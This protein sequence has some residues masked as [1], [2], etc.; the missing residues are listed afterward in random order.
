[1]P[2]VAIV[3]DHERLAGLLSQ[4]LA[5]AGIESDRFGNAR[6]A[7]YGIDR[8]DYALLIVDRGLPDGDGLAFLRTLRAAGRMM[9]C[10]MLTARDALHDRIDGLESGAD[11]Y[12]TKPFEMSELVARVR[13]LMRRPALLTTL[14]ASFADVTVDPPQRAMRCGDRTVLLAP[15][16]L[17]IML[18]LIEAGG[19]TV[20][21]SILEHA[22]WGLAEAVTPNALE[23]TVHRL[24]K[25]LTAIGATMRLTNIRGAG[26][27][28]R[29]A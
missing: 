29:D 18:C 15:A 6:E 11:D 19:R 1:M 16:E 9:P 25:K 10:L 13:T 14:V 4:A 2:R 7:A 24:R 26:F 22:A 23:V 12:V 28:L 8:A 17:Q 21:H 3:E 20:R 27:A 5:A